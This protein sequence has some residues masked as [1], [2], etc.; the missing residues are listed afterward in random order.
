QGMRPGQTPYRPDA[1]AG[2]GPG[3]SPQGPAT[4]FSSNNAQ[5]LL[6]QCAAGANVGGDL[7]PPVPG[8][9]GYTDYRSLLADLGRVNLNRALTPY[10]LPALTASNLLESGVV[11]WD[12]TQ[13]WRPDR[14]P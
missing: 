9:N 12:T 5:S 10:P 3:R 11:S 14:A 13:P 6:A 8:P 1:A 4:Y 2:P 7:R